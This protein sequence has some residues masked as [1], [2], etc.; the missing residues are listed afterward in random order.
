MFIWCAQNG[1]FKYLLKAKCECVF[2]NRDCNVA[3][4]AEIVGVVVVLVDVVV[5]VFGQRRSFTLINQ[6]MS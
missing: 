5:L 1:S 6:Q 4:A 2:G 3:D